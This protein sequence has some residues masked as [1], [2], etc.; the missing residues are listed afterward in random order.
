MSKKP[1]VLY[2]LSDEHRGQ[3][4]GHSGDPNVK[5]PWMDHLAAGGASFPRAYANCPICTPSRVQIMTGQYNFRNYVK[6]GHLARG[7]TT[8]ANLLRRGGYQTAIA[9]KWQLGGG[10]ATVKEFGFDSYCLW[11]L[12]GRESRYWDPRIETNGTLR[13]DLANRFGPD[14]MCDFVVDTI[15]KRWRKC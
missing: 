12:N 11:H 10:A 15:E 13:K 9:G 8:F 4:M 2:I 7:Q 6:F 5:T 3:A 1:H 14:V